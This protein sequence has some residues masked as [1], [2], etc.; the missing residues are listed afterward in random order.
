LIIQREGSHSIQIF[1]Q[2]VDDLGARTCFT[3]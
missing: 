2:R 1:D 3:F